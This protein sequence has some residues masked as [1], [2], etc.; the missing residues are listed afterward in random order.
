MFRFRRRVDALAVVPLGF[1]AVFF[2][3]P[4]LTLLGR[5][6]AAGLGEST[7]GWGRLV[8]VVGFTVG[9]AALSTALT[10]VVALPITWA[11]ANLSFRGRRAIRVLVTIPFVL[12]TMVVASAFVAMADRFGL[13]NGVFSL[14][15]SLSA[16]VA[17]HVFFNV[18]VV[19]RTVGGFWAQ[20]DRRPEEAAATLGANRSQVMRR[21][22]WPR[23]APAVWSALAIVFLFCFTSFAIVLVLGGPRYST[24]ETEIFRYAV[25]R[26]D[27]STAALLALVQLIAVV[28]MVLVA[29]AL[30]RRTEQGQTLVTDRARPPRTGGERLGLAA[31][32]AATGV[33]LGLPIAAMVERSL[34]V[35]EGVGLANYS[36]LAERVRLVPV[37]PIRAVVNSLWFAGVAVTIAVVVG[38]LAAIVI[39]H[40]RPGLARLTDTAVMLPLGTSAV[41]LGLGF[42]V[43]LDRG[44]LNLRGSWFIIPLA[45]ALVALP[46]VIRAVVPV[47][48]AVDP[49][50]RDVARTLGAGPREVWREI[51]LAI[52]SRALATGAG[53]GLAISMGEFGATSFVGRD[54]NLMT[55]PLAIERLLA[56]PGQMLQGQAMALSVVLMAL[57]VV[58][59]LVADRAT[60]DSNQATML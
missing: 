54:P 60:P 4:V 39:V 38:A 21:V 44:V 37:A 35:G 1:M 29:S 24:L 52:G 2:A 26:G 34:R 47:L 57:T 30:S 20:L 14:H 31:G 56:T 15:H 7:L 40:G 17:A 45:Q 16:I 25:T 55:V 28:A 43:A 50:L 18:A 3:Y 42:L 58:V 9:Q 12:P 23:L 13:D 46:F 5:G 19:V 59:V 6:L 8:R 48:R 41:T 49:T 33:L 32:Q 51:D 36:G 10:L 53:F 27:V 11:V 22:L